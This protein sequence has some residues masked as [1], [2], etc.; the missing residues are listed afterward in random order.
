MVGERLSYVDLSMFQL[1]AGLRYAFPLAMRRIE[2]ALPRLVALSARVEALP[3][4]A[5]Y[6]RSRRRLPF[7]QLGIFRHYPELDL[8]PA[9]KAPASKK[10]VAARTAPRPKTAKRAAARPARKAAVKK[11]K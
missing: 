7:N 4:I 6:L 8:Q 1:V 9:R 3:R 2:P 5:D 10:A 11:K